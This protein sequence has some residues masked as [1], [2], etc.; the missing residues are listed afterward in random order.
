[1]IMKHA[2]LFQNIL[3]LAESHKVIKIISLREGPLNGELFETLRSITSRETV[4]IHIFSSLIT[5]MQ[6]NVF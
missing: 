3:E 2:V 5:Y 1:M 6:Y 4:F